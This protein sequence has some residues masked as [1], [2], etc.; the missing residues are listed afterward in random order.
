MTLSVVASGTQTA[1]IGTEHTLSAPSASNVYQ[2]IVNLEN[3]VNGDVIELRFKRKILS[4]SAAAQTVFFATYA[5]APGTDGE[6]ALSPPAPCPHGCAVT[7]KQT[8]GTG[9]DFDWSLEGYE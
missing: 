4:G 6:L 1:S 5:N 3:M 8:A 2:L 7:L 9:R